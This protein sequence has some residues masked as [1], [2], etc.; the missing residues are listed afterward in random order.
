MIK[1][2]SFRAIALGF[3]LLP[4]AAAARDTTSCPCLSLEEKVGMAN[5]I[6]RDGLTES[7]RLN[8][9]QDDMDQ[10]GVGCAKHAD[11]NNNEWCYVDPTNC[12]LQFSSSNLFYSL[13]YSHAACGYP[14]E[15]KASTDLLRSQDLRLVIHENHRG[16]QGTICPDDPDKSTCYGTLMD[17]MADIKGLY[18]KLNVTYIETEV[19]QWITKRAANY[20]PFLEDGENLEHGACVYATSLGVV[21]ICLGAF[22]L[23]SN[24]GLLSSYIDMGVSTDYLVVQTDPN[25]NNIR[26]ILMSAF[27]PFSWSLWICTFVVLIALTSLFFVQEY[28]W[29]QLKESPLDQTAGLAVY[30]AFLGFFAQGH[31][32]GDEPRTWG[33]RFTLLAI[34]VQI[35]LGGAAYTA[36]LTN[37]LVRNGLSSS[38]QNIDDAIKQKVDVC[39]LRNRISIL[40]NSYGEGKI[41]YAIDRT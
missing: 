33:G 26:Q 5:G 35:L 16:Y 13:F 38:V 1:F 18:P 27:E 15:Y 34:A 2:V 32:T 17:M 23:N 12:E 24:R 10:F 11:I 7:L 39:V 21:D 25:R 41:Q 4:L 30:D 22:T 6:F 8:M 28:S 40:D 9:T 3:L 37:F 14:D 36:N 31:E 29:T 19:P 20:T